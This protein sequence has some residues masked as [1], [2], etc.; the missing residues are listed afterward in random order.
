[1]TYE[2]V[3]ETKASIIPTGGYIRKHLV[4]YKAV[5]YW[6]TCWHFFKAIKLLS[7]YPYCM[8][9]ESVDETCWTLHIDYRRCFP[10]WSVYDLRATDR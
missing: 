1:M 5:I 4:H 6:F 7:Y 10:P 2:T 9:Y 3:D 8:T